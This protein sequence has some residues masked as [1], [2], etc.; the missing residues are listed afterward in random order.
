VILFLLSAESA[1]ITGA[2]VP[3]DA[4]A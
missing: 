2:I 1:P 3:V 4:P